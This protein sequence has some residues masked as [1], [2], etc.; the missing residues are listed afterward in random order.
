MN[1]SSNPRLTLIGAGPGDP[2]LITVKGLKKLA[3]ADVVLYDALVN[4]TLLKYA[5]ANAEK[6]FVG[7]R[8][9]SHRFTQEEINQMIVH[10]A[11]E[12]GHVVRLKGGDPYI[13]GRGFEEYSY[14]V[15]HQ[16]PVEVV[17]GIS[18][19]TGLASLR[20]LPV[21]L[22]GI[23]ESFWIVTGTTKDCEFSKDIQIAAQSTATVI[24]LMGMKKLS[25]IAQAYRQIGKGQYSVMVIQNGSLEEER[26]VIGKIDSIEKLVHE[27]NLSSPAVILVGMV[28]DQTKKCIKENGRLLLNSFHNEHELLPKKIRGSFSKV[29]S[30]I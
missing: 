19:A 17:P 20:H 16:I 1:R 22:R 26:S 18:S 25:M 30:N 27:Q 13:F 15:N 23:S 9:G 7:K 11:K 8:S 2:D 21:T 6:I 10:Y 3:E 24:I 14:A 12:R 5:R 29:S 28:I 4:R